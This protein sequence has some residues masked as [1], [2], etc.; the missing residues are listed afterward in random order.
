MYFIQVELCLSTLWLLASCGISLPWNYGLAIKRNKV[1]IHAT[2]Q[3]KL[4]KSLLVFHSKDLKSLSLKCISCPPTKFASVIFSKYYLPLFNLYLVSMSP[5]DG[6][7]FFIAVRCCTSICA[8]TI[9]FTFFPHKNS[10][11]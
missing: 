6:K 1:L 5:L 4:K 2:T 7:A 3:T 10:L 9:L 11:I 8:G